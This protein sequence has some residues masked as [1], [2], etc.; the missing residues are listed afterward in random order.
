MPGPVKNKKTAKDSALQLVTPFLI[1]QSKAEAQKKLTEIEKLV[2]N[3]HYSKDTLDLILIFM[4]RWKVNLDKFMN[5][6]DH[7]GRTTRDTFGAYK[8]LREIIDFSDILE[9]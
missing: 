9:E 2:L 6:L 8:A 7:G 5:S 1:S 3:G 4:K